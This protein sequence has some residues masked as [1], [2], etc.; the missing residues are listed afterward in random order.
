M[1]ENVFREPNLISEMMRAA[2]A[3]RTLHVG[4]QDYAPGLLSVLVDLWC[5]LSEEHQQKLLQME[6]CQA[7]EIMVSALDDAVLYACLTN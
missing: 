6:P 5:G 4:G 3:R 2:N 7:L 1:L